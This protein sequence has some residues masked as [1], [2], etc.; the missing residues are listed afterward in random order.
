MISLFIKPVTYENMEVANQ[1]SLFILSD[2]NP[3]LDE[4]NSLQVPN[5]LQLKITIHFC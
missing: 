2:V 1:I 4:M 3:T 5:D